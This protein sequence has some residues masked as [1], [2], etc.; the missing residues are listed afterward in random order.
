MPISRLQK[1][2]L[3]AD[4]VPYLAPASVSV[5]SLLQAGS[6]RVFQK[7]VFNLFTI[8]ARIERVRVHI[9]ERLGISGPQYSL[10]RAVASLQGR[11]GVSIGIVAEHLQVTS[12]F[13]TAQ[14]RRLAQ[15]GLLKKE[16]DTTDRRVSRLS[17]TMK[18][19]RLV[20]QIVKGV[21]PINDIFFG[22]LQKGEFEALAAIMEKL[23]DSSRHA[24][25][26]ISSEDKDAL[27]SLRD[28]RTSG[29]D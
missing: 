25:I 13:V 18:G 28:N 16:E 5:P 10:L 19:E 3:L 11:E 9:A 15:C 7:L 21:R 4:G 23:V 8:S 14:S 1:H 27:L 24:M 22:G 6:D 17:L 2:R 29:S 26:Q 20:D 12:T